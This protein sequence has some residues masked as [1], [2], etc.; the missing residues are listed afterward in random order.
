MNCNE[1]Q[2]EFLTNK[3]TSVARGESWKSFW[4]F[5]DPRG[6]RTTGDPYCRSRV[7][8]LPRLLS[9]RLSPA[10]QQMRPER[11]S[12]PLPSNRSRSLI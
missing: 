3:N 10:A 4:P 1:N 12:R 2:V 5:F 7:I 8:F 11:L 6:T 9:E